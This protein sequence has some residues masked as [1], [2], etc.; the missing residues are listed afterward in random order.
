MTYLPP[1]QT[2]ITNYE[3]KVF[4][5]STELALKA[6]MEYVHVIV[7]VGA[8]IK[9]YHLIWNDPERWKRIIIHLGDF[10]SFMAFFGVIGKFI[11][12]SGF[13]EIVYQSD[14]CTSGSLNAVL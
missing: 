2:P 11:S 8:A 7:G 1:I 5:L 14:L 3:T 6:N 12:G 9:A 10:H 4:S 13:E